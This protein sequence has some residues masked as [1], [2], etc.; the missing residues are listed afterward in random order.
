MWISYG[1]GDGAAAFD[2]GGDQGVAV[3][4]V[5]DVAADA[6]V[7]PAQFGVQRFELAQASRG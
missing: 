6:Q 5:G 4:A 1:V 3:V 7:L 2:G